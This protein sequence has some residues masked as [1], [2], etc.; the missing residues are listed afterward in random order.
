[1][2]I[3]CMKRG[4]A[5]GSVKQLI[6]TVRRVMDKEFTPDTL[7]ISMVVGYNTWILRTSSTEVLRTTWQTNST[8]AHQT[9]LA[10]STASGGKHHRRMMRSLYRQY[11]H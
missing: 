7:A 8:S 4:S 9:G 1:V 10:K 11:H 6:V 2:S 3:M 5:I